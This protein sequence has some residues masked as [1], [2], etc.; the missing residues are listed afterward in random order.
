MITPEISIVTA[1]YNRA[2]TILRT[3][4]SLKRQTFERYEHIIV[5]DGSKDDTYERIADYVRS[6][7]RVT[8]VRKANGGAVSAMN[9]GITLACAPFVTFLDSDDAYEKEHLALRLAYLAKHPDVDFLWGGLRCVG[10]KSR[11]YFPDLQRPGKLI[12]SS[13]CRVAGTLVV[14]RSLLTRVKGFR[15]LVSADYDLCQRLDA[16]GAKSAR[17]RHPTLIYYVAGNDRMSVT[18]KNTT[19]DGKLAAE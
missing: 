2:S 5:D 19:A 4:A 7:P 10:P 9:T 12:H 16:R 3:I 15:K 1:T 14:R 17:V 18:R 6:D 11:Q 13:E 8:Y